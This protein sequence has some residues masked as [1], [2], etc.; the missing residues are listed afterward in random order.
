MLRLPAA[1]LL[2]QGSLAPQSITSRRLVPAVACRKRQPRPVQVSSSSSNVVVTDQAVPEGHKGLHGFLYGEQGAEVHEDSSRY[3]R[4]RVHSAR[5]C[6]F[7][8][9]LGRH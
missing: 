6:W 5:Y 1:E 8:G 3:E 4:V 7:A 2:F 9:A